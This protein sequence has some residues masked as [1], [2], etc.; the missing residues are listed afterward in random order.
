MAQKV[1][2]E[3]EL[4]RSGKLV[5]TNVG[6]SMMPLLREGRDVMLI[7]ACDESMLHCYDAVLFKRH[8]VSGRGAYVLHRILK[9]LPGGKYWIVG[10]NCITGEVVDGKDILGI[11]TQVQRGG[12]KIIRNTDFS[13]R[14]YVFF[15]CR[16]YHLRFFIL[17]CGRFIRRGFRF[18][19]RAG[20]KK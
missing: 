14:M 20:H 2:F 3:E 8:G 7:E 17:R 16:P 15:W 11:L 1:T 5:Y 4:A 12:K 10:D 9:V 18:L 19:K 6:V 13:Y